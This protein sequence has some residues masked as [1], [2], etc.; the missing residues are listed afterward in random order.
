MM[1]VQEDNYTQ[2]CKSSHVRNRVRDYPSEVIISKIS[3][4]TE[5]KMLKLKN[6]NIMSK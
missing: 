2:V 5:L 1:N 6:Y 4:Y 3:A